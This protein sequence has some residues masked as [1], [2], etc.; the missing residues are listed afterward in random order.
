M[1]FVVVQHLAPNQESN[2]AAI[3]Q[4]F[5]RMV[6][7]ELTEKTSL[8]PNH[9]YIIP[10]NAA[11]TLKAGMLHLS[12]PSEDRRSISSVDHFFQ[13]LAEDLHECAIGVV[14]SGTRR[15]GSNGVIAIKERGGLTFA[16]APEDAEYPSMPQCAIDTGRVDLILTAGDIARRLVSFAAGDFSHERAADDREDHLPESEAVY[17]GIIAQLHRSTGHDFSHYKRATMSRRID[18]RRQILQQPNLAAYLSCLRSDRNEASALFNAVLIGVTAFFRDPEAFEALQDELIVKLFDAKEDEEPIRVWIP[19]CSTGEEVY[20]IAMLLWEEAS[21]RKVVADFKIFA[22]DLD[23]RAV[24]SARRG[25]YSAAACANISSARLS[26]FFTAEGGDYRVV[27]ELRDRTLFA[28]HDILKDPPFGRQH[29]MSCRNLL[30]YLDDEAQRK[31]LEIAHYAVRPEGFLFLGAS[32]FIGS[33]KEYFSTIS[34]AHRLYRPKSLSRRRLPLNN[35][36]GSG[37]T[38]DP[39]HA[40]SSRFAFQQS[41]TVDR[42]HNELLAARYAPASVLIDR[43]GAICHI[44]GDVSPYLR[45]APG[46]LTADILH[47]AHPDLRLRLRTAMGTA[48]ERKGNTTTSPIHL[49]ES[50][51]P[52]SVRIYVQPVGAPDESSHEYAMVIFEPEG[53]N[54]PF[55]IQE[56]IEIADADASMQAVV[57]RLE[58]ENEKTRRTLDRTIE[59]YETTTEELKTSNEEL[60]TI[61]EELQSTSEELETSKEEL[62]STNEELITVNEELSHKLT[63]LDDVNNDLKNLLSATNIGTIFLDRKLNLRRFTAP[64]QSY[65]NLLSVDLGRPFDHITHRLEYN[66][67]I[68]DARAVL[69]DLRAI[70]RTVR[71]DEGK[72]FIMRLLPYRTIDDRIDG[73]VITFFDITDREEVSRRSI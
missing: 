19:A 16:Q 33:S 65:F 26:R 36:T 38:Q 18:R 28:V 8:A 55:S 57:E 35:I 70:E 51:K 4:R 15:D 17:R 43:S 73:V 59:R 29:L 6:V 11:L 3:L 31:V 5:T 47:M 39:V 54:A 56:T 53:E 30:I 42:L 72:W 67:M 63:E 20:T 7:I 50:A 44:V 24:E 10:P 71:S 9:V 48:F 69:K 21:R 12:E 58:Q 64:I 37:S 61:N 46:H 45:M 68:D 23:A 60:L 25:V 27:K 13:S 49:A 14:L 52:H 2:L 34:S 66:G 41:A 62:Q 22:T 40:E 32:E 1:A